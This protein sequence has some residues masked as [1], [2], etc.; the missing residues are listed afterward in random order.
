MHLEYNLKSFELTA[1]IKSKSNEWEN[2]AYDSFKELELWKEWICL[3]TKFTLKYIVDSSKSLKEQLAETRK[4][5]CETNKPVFKIDGTEIM[6][7]K[8]KVMI[9][10]GKNAKVNAAL[11]QTKKDQ[12]NSNAKSDPTKFEV[13]NFILAPSEEESVDDISAIFASKYHL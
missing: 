6:L 1:K 8:D 7:K 9:G 4:K 11:Q 13:L 10:I 12:S 3:R 2:V 5:L